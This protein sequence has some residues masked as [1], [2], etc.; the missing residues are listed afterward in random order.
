MLC[1]R[2]FRRLLDAYYFVC[3][4]FHY[5]SLAPIS[6]GFLDIFCL[7]MA[8]LMPLFRRLSSLPYTLYAII[9]CLINID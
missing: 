9:D 5:I 3:R 4:R 1:Q 8:M 7:L 6:P 2:L